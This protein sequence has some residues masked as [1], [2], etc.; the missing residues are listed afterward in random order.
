MKSIF[1]PAMRLSPFSTMCGIYALALSVSFAQNL[2][3]ESPMQKEILAMRGSYEKAVATAITPISRSYVMALEK[4][5]ANA[6]QK[7]DDVA[8]AAIDAEIVRV[9]GQLQTDAALQAAF[10]GSQ[11]KWFSSSNLTGE[12]KAFI[13][14]YRGGV[15]RTSWGNRVRYVILPPASLRVS[16]DNPKQDWYFVVDLQ[17]KQALADPFFSEGREK[18]S[19]SWDRSISPVEPSTPP[20]PAY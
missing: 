4:L 2:P 19:L 18:R 17:K 13:D 15:A 14:F 7:K 11:W 9:R 1:L 12:G 10:V 6:K 8:L 3:V 20:K 5:S 16:Q